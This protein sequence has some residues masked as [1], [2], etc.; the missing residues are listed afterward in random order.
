[1]RGVEQVSSFDNG[2]ILNALRSTMIENVEAMELCKTFSQNMGRLSGIAEQLY[3][4]SSGKEET[5]V[6]ACRAD[7]ME[8]TRTMTRALVELIGL[9]G[10]DNPSPRNPH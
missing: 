3:R 2:T 9:A 8:V 10:T 4:H 1:M 6:A 5:D 7:S